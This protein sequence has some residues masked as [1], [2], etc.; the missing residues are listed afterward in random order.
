MTELLGAFPELAGTPLAQP[1]VVSFTLPIPIAIVMTSFAPGGTEGQ[2]IELVRRLDSSRWSVYLVCF[3]QRGAWFERA[4]AAVRSVVEFPVTS[5]KH[6][7]TAKHLWAF[8][9]WC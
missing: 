2:M 6:P 8:A 1:C 3:A 9:K 7:S 5:F 4:A